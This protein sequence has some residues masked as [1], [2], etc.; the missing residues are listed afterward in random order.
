MEVRKRE[1]VGREEMLQAFSLLVLA[2]I[3]TQGVA[4]GWDEAGPLALLRR[5]AGLG[6]GRAVGPGEA[7]RRG[8]AEAGA[9]GVDGGVDAFGEAA[10]VAAGL[11]AG[12][13]PVEIPLDGV[14]PWFEL[15]GF[16]GAVG[17]ADFGFPEGPG[18]VAAGGKVVA[19]AEVLEPLEEDEEGGAIAV[20]EAAEG[21]EVLAPAP[22]GSGGGGWW[23]GGGRGGKAKG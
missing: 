5:C 4:L 6:W 23:H 21:G 15:P 13:E 10:V 1:A 12:L 8:M 19:E 18:G 11:G 3:A 22:A 20:G 16:A 14:A 9:G 17:A 2:G 7:V